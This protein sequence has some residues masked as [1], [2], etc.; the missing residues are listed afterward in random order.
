MLARTGAIAST[1]VREFEMRKFHGFGLFLVLSTPAWPGSPSADRLAKV[2]PD[3]RVRAL[4]SGAAY[5]VFETTEPAVVRVVLIDLLDSDV[6]VKPV[7]A[8][9]LPYGGGPSARERVVDMAQRTGALAMI[10]AD[11]AGRVD[12]IEG[13][14]VLE[15]KF[16]PAPKPVRRSA[17]AIG[18][19]RRARIGLWSD[20]QEAGFE[21]RHAVGGGPRM[22]YAGKFRWDAPPDGSINDEDMRV[23]AGRW[24]IPHS[25]SAVCVDQGGRW[26]TWVVAH[27]SA[28]ARGVG[29]TPSRLG[30]VMS[31]LSCWD[32]LRFDG[33]GSSTLVVEGALVMPM[34]V[35]WQGGARLGSGL[36]LYHRKRDK[37]GN[38]KV[39]PTVPSKTGR[40]GQ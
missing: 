16:L 31:R 11:Y 32:A 4:S 37:E 9:N 30:E 27:A 7:V 17:L 19:D 33:G 23:P 12:N 1:V 35:Q 20:P 38:Q 5:A 10:N 39:A 8:N 34:F 15:G 24:D 40:S 3:V 26:M 28:P 36:G 29:L 18:A 21:M 6:E 2:L 13:F 25:L 14:L 22:M